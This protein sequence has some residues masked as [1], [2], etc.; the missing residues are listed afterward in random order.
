MADLQS[1]Y[2]LTLKD[3]LY[4]KKDGSPFPKSNSCNIV[5]G[6]MKKDGYKVTPVPVDDGF[7]LRVLKLDQSS[8]ANGPNEEVSEQ[9]QASNQK[10][11]SG[12]ESEVERLRRELAEK[13]SK[14][15]REIAELKGMVQGEG[16]AAESQPEQQVTRGSSP[17]GR[18]KRKPFNRNRIKFPD[19]PGY[20]RRL[21][22]N[23]EGGMR[24]RAFQEAGWK[25]VEDPYAKVD[26]DDDVNRPSQM[27]SSVSR[28]V[29]TNETGDSLQGVLMEIPEEYY[30]EDQ[31]AKQED[32]DKTE[33]GLREINKD[34]VTG[35]VRASGYE[36]EVN[37]RI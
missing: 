4:Y 18:P 21:V 27:G 35:G 22:N 5:R 36:A 3:G 13:E 6:K 28:H 12:T 20:R 32:V 37:R 9:S 15:E 25:V 31:Q 29:G 16:K 24:I 33:R 30:L 26:S 11:E 7:A 17:S 2:N 19:R 14:F 8:T 1:T 23:T 34:G 10:P